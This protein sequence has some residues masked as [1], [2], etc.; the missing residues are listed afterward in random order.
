MSVPKYGRIT[1]IQGSMLGL[2]G[3]VLDLPFQ[4][5]TDEQRLAEMKASKDDLCQM[6][7]RDF[8]FNLAAWHHYLMNSEKHAEQYTFPYAWKAV[9]PKILE[10]IQDPNRLRL[11]QLL[12]TKTKQ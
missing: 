9:E 5:P 4:E 8:G 12:E 7:G 11:V 2:G 1:P 10:L 6:T 3:E